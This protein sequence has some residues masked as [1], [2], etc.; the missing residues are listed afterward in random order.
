MLKNHLY[1]FLVFLILGCTTAMATAETISYSCSFRIYASPEGLKTEEKPFELKYIIDRT[2]K[3]AYIVGNNGSA[4]VTEIPNL[5]GVSFLEVTGSGNIMVT[6]I[7][8]DGDAV[9]S[10]HSMD[11]KKIIPTQYYGKCKKQ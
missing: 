3:K 1:P 10:R 8:S 11:A 9:H 4:Q 2:T 7:T 5:G 6:A